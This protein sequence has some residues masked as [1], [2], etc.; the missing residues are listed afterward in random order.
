M[1]LQQAGLDPSFVIGGEISEVGSS[2]HHGTG[3]HF[4]V[5]AD[6]S[7]RSF[8]HLPPVRLDHH[9]HRG[10]PPQH[11]RRPGRRWRRRSSSSPGSPTRTGSS[12]PAPTTRAA[13][14]WPRALRAEGRRVYTYGEARRRRPAADR[15]A[16]PPR[17]GCATWPRSTAGRWASSGCRCRGGTWGSTAPPRCWPRYLL[18]LPLEAAEAAL[19]VVPRRAA[20]LRAQGRRRRRAG[21][22]RVRLP[23]DLDDRWRCRRCA[24]W[25]ATAG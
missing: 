10:R 15:D 16:S 2:A 25:P 21:L 5:E 7:D 1:V 14:G 24:R 22:R 20:A 18:G 4:V 11:L 9:Q 17:A 8:L 3:E 12:S 13:G 6:E 19:A 23:P